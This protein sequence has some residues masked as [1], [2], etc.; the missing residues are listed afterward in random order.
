MI[1]GDNITYKIDIGDPSRV[2]F[3]Q[4]GVLD[5]TTI[6]GPHP[7]GNQFPVFAISRDFGTI[8]STQA[9]F[10]WAV[11]YTSDPAISYT[12]LSGAP[13]T[14]RYSYYKSKYSDDGALVSAAFS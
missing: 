12:D 6:T 8:Q 14:Q 4:S 10:V 5:N 11:G 3:V 1:Q 13:A 9:P 7:I 2:M